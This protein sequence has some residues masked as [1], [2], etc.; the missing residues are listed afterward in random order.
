MEGLNQDL[1]HFLNKL[2]ASDSTAKTVEEKWMELKTA[3]ISTS[4]KHIWKKDQFGIPVLRAN[5]KGITDPGILL[6]IDVDVDE[7]STFEFICYTYYLN[8]AVSFYS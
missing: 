4:K 2:L 3:L 1:E 5:G 8:F 6:E 7:Q